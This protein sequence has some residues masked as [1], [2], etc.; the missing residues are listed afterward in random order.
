MT[1]Y[2]ST[3]QCRI[4]LDN[5]RQCTIIWDYTSA[6]SWPGTHQAQIPPN[7]T[8]QELSHFLYGFLYTIAQG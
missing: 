3:R 7:H 4:I 5:S 2:N 6:Q 8:L 1:I